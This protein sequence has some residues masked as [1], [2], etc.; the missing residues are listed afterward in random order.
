MGGVSGGDAGLFETAALAGRR[1]VILTTTGGPAD[2]FTTNGTFGHIDDFLFPLNRGVLEFV[3]YDALEPIITFG[4]AHL[5]DAQRAKAL[6]AV[7][8][9]FDD[10]QT[11][12]LASTSRSRANAL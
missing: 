11:R 10:L 7:R 6:G 1:A 2:A 5:D 8:Q 12:P 9:A 3:G 4:P